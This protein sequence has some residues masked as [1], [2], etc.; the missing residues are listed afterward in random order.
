[1]MLLSIAIRPKTSQDAQRLTHAL[2]RFAAEDAPIESRA[3]EE[4]VV[5]GGITLE[6]IEAAIAIG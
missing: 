1:M 5:L 2:D 3:L 4:H 6:H